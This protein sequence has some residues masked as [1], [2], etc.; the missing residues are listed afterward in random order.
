[1]S[2][3]RRGADLLLQV[4][5]AVLNGKLGSGF[6]QI[7][8]AEADCTS[9]LAVAAR[10]L[11]LLTLSD[12][13]RSPNIKGSSPKSSSCITRSTE[14]SIW[15]AGPVSAFREER[16]EGRI[17]TSRVSHAPRLP[18]VDLHQIWSRYSEMHGQILAESGQIRSHAAIDK[19]RRSDLN[20]L[21]QCGICDKW[22]YYD[23]TVWRLLYY[24]DIF[25]MRIHFRWQSTV[26]DA[27]S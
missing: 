18:N 10:S 5:C 2:W 17:P 14:C 26:F 16:D 25:I 20:G 23:D 19:F 21:A 9:D 7:S 11:I 1:M 13:T 12:A 3:S 6:D 8:K 27:G 24:Y 4:C 15:R 22:Y